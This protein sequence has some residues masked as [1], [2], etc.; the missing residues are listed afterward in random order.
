MKR[1]N[2]WC[3]KKKSKA[4]SQGLRNVKNNALELDLQPTFK[5]EMGF[6]N[7]YAS[8]QIRFLYTRQKGKYILL[9]FFNQQFITN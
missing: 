7:C 5:L 2:V 9:F 3:Y 4:K 1:Y 6:F 8:G